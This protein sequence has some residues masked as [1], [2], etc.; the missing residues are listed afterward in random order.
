MPERIQQRRT[1]GWRKPEGV[2]SVARGTD[3]GNPYP[4]GGDLVLDMASKGWPAR[5][6]TIT[7]S[8]AVALYREYLAQAYGPGIVDQ[9]QRELGG[10]DLM[11]WCPVG[12][13]CHGDLL[14]EI[15]NSAR[16]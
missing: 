15:A 7:P 8:L 13:P 5:A 3:W 14:L 10:R 4:V 6:L 11:C 1:K 16:P 9:I 2:I 12:R